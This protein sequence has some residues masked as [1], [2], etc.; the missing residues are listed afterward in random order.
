MMLSGVLWTLLALGFVIF[1]H[2]LGHMLAARQVGV[3]VFEFAIGFG[4]RVFSKK[5]GGTLY[6]LRILPIG[7]FVKLAGL[8]DSEDQVH[9]SENFNFKKLRYRFWIIVAGA[10]MNVVLGWVIYTGM[11]MFAGVPEPTSRIGVVLEG[12]PAQAAGLL[13]GDR[14]TH[15]NGRGVDDIEADLISVV[16]GA[17]GVETVFEVVRDGV[18]KTVLITP[19]AS[20]HR[21]DRGL[22][23]VQFDVDYV[24][25]SPLKSVQVG[26]AKTMLVVSQVFLSFKLLFSGQVGFSDMAG[27]VGIVQMASF[28]LKRGVLNFLTIIALIS[29]SL[30]VINLFPIPPL[31]GWHALMLGYEG[32]FKKAI[33]EKIIN[34][35]MQ[36]GMIFLLAVMVLV[37]FND[38]YHWKDRV[39]LFK[40]FY[41]DSSPK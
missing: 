7:G 13:S 10:F 15:V 20:E 29:I 25:Y 4:P 21:V 1:I 16:N 11:A 12:M 35:I 5:V 6:S 26:T 30:G 17:L 31:D 41:Q 24:H 40:S 8:D 36:G 27:P 3:R 22:I 39:T 19:V 23:G 28:E 33:P 37:V 32:V 18:S 9:D 14:I 34:W 38:V 2:E